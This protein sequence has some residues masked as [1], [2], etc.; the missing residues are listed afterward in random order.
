MSMNKQKID[1]VQ[2]CLGQLPESVRVRLV[3]ECHAKLKEVDLIDGLGRVVGDLEVCNAAW[4]SV[5]SR[6]VGVDPEA[7]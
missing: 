7:S 3:N 2:E 6:M 4:T 1:R 5:M